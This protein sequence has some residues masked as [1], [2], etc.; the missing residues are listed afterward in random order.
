M[1]NIRF[2]RVGK[3]N[4][5]YFRIV[6]IEHTRKVGG[7]YKE[8][9]GSYNPRTKALQLGRER[10]QY[11]LSKGVKASPTAHNLFVKEGV[12]AGPKVQAWKPKRK[13]GGEKA[14]KSSDAA[15]GQAPQNFVAGQAPQSGEVAAG[16]A[17]E[18]KTEATSE[19]TVFEKEAAVSEAPIAGQEQL[20]S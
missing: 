1:L 19:V 14:P 13:E 20:A 4:Q 18:T 11:W 16:Q 8:M 7:K 10:V 2:Q 6:L 15:T 17:S 9:L 5:P 12:V 3:K